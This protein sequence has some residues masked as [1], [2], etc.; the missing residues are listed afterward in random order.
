AWFGR[1]PAIL[2]N[3]QRQP[4]ANVIDVVDRVEALLPALKQSLPTGVDVAV[5]SDRTHTIRDS[6]EHVQ[7]E[8][9][10]A[11]LLVV[12]VT[13]VFLRTWKATFIPSVVVPL[14]LVGTFGLMFMLG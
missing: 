14:S 10:L 1:T 8:M 11:V 6:V 13:F 7:I 2:L 12:A 3:I 9:L 5:A 4:G